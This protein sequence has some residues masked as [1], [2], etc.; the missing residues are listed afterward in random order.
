MFINKYI[1]IIGNK[2]KNYKFI[3]MIFSVLIVG[4]ILMVTSLEM[5]APHKK[6]T[7][8]LDINDISVK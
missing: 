7:K 8:S 3:L 6:I 4:L 2:M 1:S 5:P